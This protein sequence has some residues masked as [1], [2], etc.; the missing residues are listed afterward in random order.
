MVTSISGKGSENNIF[1][2]YRKKSVTEWPKCLQALEWTFIQLLDHSQVFTHDIQ[3]SILTC[4][5]V[6]KHEVLEVGDL[7]SLPALGHIGGLEELSRRGQRNSPVNKIKKGCTHS[8]R[9]NCSKTNGTKNRE[10]QSIYP[11]SAY[12]S[13]P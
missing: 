13:G 4:N 1:V 8:L 10:H 3:V 6:E 5:G 11:R 9:T 2:I 7:P 12:P